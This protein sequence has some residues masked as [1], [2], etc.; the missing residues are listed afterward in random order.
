MQFENIDEHK[1][2]YDINVNI[3]S[4]ILIIKSI[5]PLMV[6]KNFGHF[7]NISSGTSIFGLPLTSMYSLSKASLQSFFESLYFESYKKNI[8][9]KNFF[10]GI[11]D[12]NNSKYLSK[13]ISD[14]IFSKKLNIYLKKYVFIALILK[15]FPSL[16]K[17]LSIIQK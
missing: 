4:Q 11:F 9:F 15:L 16:Y 3:L 8:Y 13:K 14:K 1:I 17:L 7:I 2:T 12:E 6:N 5:L 10:T